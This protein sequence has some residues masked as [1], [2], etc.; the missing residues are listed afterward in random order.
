MAAVQ[1]LLS[2]T[3]K[4]PGTAGKSRTDFATGVAVQAQAVGGP[5]AAYQWSFVSKAINEAVGARASSAF[6]SATASTTS[7]SP[8]DVAGDYLIQLAVDSGSGLGATSDDVAR[9]MF[10]AGDP[11][12]D[13]TTGPLNSD[14]AELP[15]RFPAF[16]EQLEDNVNDAIDPSGN[17]EGWSRTMR[18]FKSVIDRIYKGKSWA[19]GRVAQTGGGCVLTGGFNVGTPSR[20]GVGTAHVTFTRTLP[21][22]N[23]AVLIGPR[24]AAGSAV[25]LNETVTGFDVE[26]ADVGGTLADLD[27]VFDV[28]VPT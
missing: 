24:G 28:K 1:I 2:Q 14:P 12:G 25:A 19:F 15:Q 20:T 27:W 23:Y 26:R 9:I 21:N 10:Y 5:F 22:A 3:G 6:G 17:A 13:C 11:A 7:V 8:I 18:R 16:R 4:P